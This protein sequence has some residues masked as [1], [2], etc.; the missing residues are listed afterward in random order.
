MV[1]LIALHSIR[2]PP[3]GIT[4]NKTRRT[5]AQAGFVDVST[6]VRDSRGH[7][8]NLAGLEA[9]AAH[10]QASVLAVDRGAHGL[11]VRA[12]AT[13]GTTVRMGNG[14]TGLRSLAA[15]CATSCHDG[16]P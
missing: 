6:L 3:N 2:K 10:A 14:E 8:L 15:H 13:L 9:F 5:E 1:I 16:L 4:Y 7:A 12:E 11:Q